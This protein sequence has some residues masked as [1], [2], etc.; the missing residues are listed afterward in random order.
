[1][2]QRHV[3]GVAHPIMLFDEPYLMLLMTHQPPLHQLWLLH[4]EYSMLFTQS[5]IYW[6]SYIFPVHSQVCQPLLMCMCPMACQGCNSSKI[7]QTHCFRLAAC[8]CSCAFPVSFT[9][10]LRSGRPVLMQWMSMQRKRCVWAAIA[11]W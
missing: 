9:T 11:R 2:W 5:C 7:Y 6:K 8:A 10:S 4:A 1:M 3:V